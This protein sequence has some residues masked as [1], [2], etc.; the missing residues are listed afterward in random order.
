MKGGIE[1][2]TGKLINKISNRLRRRSKAAQA[3]LRISGAKGN[4]LRFILAEGVERNG[5][6]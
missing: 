1:M 5:Y 3:A 4:I 2:E 6:Q